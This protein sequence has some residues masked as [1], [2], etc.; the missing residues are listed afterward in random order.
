MVAVPDNY[1]LSD[2]FAKAYR[3]FNLLTFKREMMQLSPEQ[4]NYLNE[5]FTFLIYAHVLTPGDIAI[6]VGAN[7]GMHTWGMSGLVGPTGT[8]HAFEPNPLLA[9]YLT[10]VGNNVIFHPV[11]V[12]DRAETAVFFVS[13][14]HQMSS[15]LEHRKRFMKENAGITEITVEVLP[16]D[17]MPSLADI[18]PTCVKIDVE[19]FEINAL[20][21]MTRLIDRARPTILVEQATPEIAAF[22]AE[23]GYL[24][25]DFFGDAD[26][27]ESQAVANFVAI[28]AE[29]PTNG[30]FITEIDLAFV[31]S[32]YLTIS[33]VSDTGSI[34]RG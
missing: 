13:E 15:L 1:Y 33:T 10:G 4:K 25:R 8:V 16:L 23:R 20:R 12:G 24:T 34:Q 29:R 18:L 6:D 7:L 26:I 17:Q 31:F 3:R 14:N 27:L 5:R 9:P 2:F 19:G 32:H 28:P 22:F 11:A 30:I 21:G